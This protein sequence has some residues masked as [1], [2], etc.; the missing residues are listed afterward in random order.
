M[1]S[2]RGVRSL[3]LPAMVLVL[4]V[5][6]FPAPQANHQGANEGFI[7][8]TSDRANPSNLGICGNCEDTYGMSPDG[9]HAK[10]LTHGGGAADDPLAYSSGGADWHSTTA[11]GRR[12]ATRLR[13][14][15]WPDG[16]AG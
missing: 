6:W 4:C 15:L 11:R 16:C 2:I 5:A 1:R 14:C 10:R 8:F 12:G 3:S 7:V 13:G 9:S